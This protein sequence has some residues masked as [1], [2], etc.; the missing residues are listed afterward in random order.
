MAYL[1]STPSKVLLARSTISFLTRWTKVGPFG[2]PGDRLDNVDVLSDQYRKFQGGF[3][4]P[5]SYGDHMD[6]AI[7]S[8]S[9][10]LGIAI[11]VD[12]VNTQAVKVIVVV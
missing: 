3:L 6:R 7:K 12:L 9:K 5:T 11:S 2:K 4:H 1:L 8:L 10:D